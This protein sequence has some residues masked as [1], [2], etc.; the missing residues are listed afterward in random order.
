MTNIFG[1]NPATL[2]NKKICTKCVNLKPTSF[3]RQ[4]ADVFD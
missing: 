4:N 1:L 3:W 2:V